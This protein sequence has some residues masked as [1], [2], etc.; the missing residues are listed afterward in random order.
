MEAADS[1]SGSYAWKSILKGRDGLKEGMRWKVGIGAAI[2]IWSD[3]WMPFDFL[4]Y[5]S[6]PIVLEFEEALVNFLINLST[7]QWDPH[8][9]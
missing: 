2:W 8:I 6:Y 1:Y 7:K 5:I 3:P 9:C 4:P